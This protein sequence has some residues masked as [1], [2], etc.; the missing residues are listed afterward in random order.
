MT[1]HPTALPPERLYSPCDPDCFSFKT[2]AEL[3]VLTDVIGQPR[4]VE[5]VKFAIGMRHGGYNLF[6]HGPEGTGK[7]S[8]THQFLEREARAEPAPEDWCYVHNFD[9]LHR[10]R[11]LALPPGLG[12]QL[13]ADMDRLL[14]EL[15]AAIPAAFESDEYRN[16]KNAIEEQY[17]ERQEEAFAEFQKRAQNRDIALIRTPVGLA[18]APTKDGEVLNPQQF[19]ELSE[20]EQDR[21]KEAMEDLQKDLEDLLHATPKRQKEQREEIKAL[22]RDV[23]IYAVGHLIDTIKKDW[24][25]QASVLNHLDAVRNDVVENAAA[26]LPHEAQG[27]VAMLGGGQRAPEGVKDQVFRKYQVN[28]LVDNTR[29]KEG[30]A[31]PGAPVIEEDHPTQPNLIGRIEH[32]SHLGTLVTDFTLIKPGA[33]HRANGGYLIM[34]AR[35]L[36]MQPFAWETLMRTLRAE[37]L[38]IE[39]PGEAL[40]W[41]TTQTLQPEPI[42]LRTKVVLLGEPWLYYLL[43]HY[44]P[45]FRELFKVVA[46]FDNRMDRTDEAAMQYARLIATLGEKDNLKPFDRGAAARM[47]EYGARLADDA[48]KLSTHMGKVVDLVH[49][50]DFWAGQESADTVTATHVQQAIDAKIYRSDRIRERIQEEIQR[51][52]LVIETDGTQV[53]QVNA[54]SVVQLDGFAF[55]RPS[56]I[57]CTVRLGKGEVMDIERE[58][59]LGGPLHSKGV[60]ILTSFLGK[61]FG[62][63]QPLSLTASLVFEQSYGGVDGDSASSTEL[64]ALLSAIAD[65]PIGQFLA[66]TGSVDQHGN[67]QAIGGV[68]EKIEGFFDVCAQ[69]GLTGEQGVLI[70]AANVK[71]LMLRADVVEAAAKGTFHIYPVATID[72]GIQLLTGMEA[73]EADKKGDYP[74]GSVNRAVA[75]GLETLTKQARAQARKAQPANRRFQGKKSDKDE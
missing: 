23:T 44:D 28:V 53:G 66:V 6:V 38:R 8:L 57:S 74:I 19:E 50:A 25:G 33:L 21:R 62:R 43:T 75:L 36:L 67:V 14:E 51:G 4:A 15:T 3:A 56:R 41:V 45:D 49:E 52:T 7:S 24:Q 69:R 58:V 64:Y 55:G 9:E 70:P 12:C 65:I 20:K 35:K 37:R 71:H 61:R 54:L 47:V 42:P 60:M 1:K 31:R 26:F 27:V 73:G 32:I 17:K 16:R 29:A 68:N 34:D 46:D 72:E 39:G 2:T 59:A 40:G 10:P 18:L 30:G 48:E 22:D 11:A 13:R 5:A 63:K